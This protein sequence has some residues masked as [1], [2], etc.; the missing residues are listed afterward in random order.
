MKIYI[1]SCSPPRVERLL[2]AA[3]PLHLDFEV[4]DS[5]LGTDEEV[6]RRG[7][8][9]LE[10][11]SGYATGIAATIGHIRA[12][13]RITSRDDPLAIIIEDDVRFHTKFNEYLEMCVSYM[14]VRPCD[15]LSMGYVNMPNLYQ[16]VHVGDLLCIE[17]V[18][19]GNPWGAQCYLITKQYASYFSK[20][21]SGD[22]LATPYDGKFVTD[23]VMF[24]PKLKCN[25][26][27]LYR[28]IVV[29]D[30]SEQTLAGNNNKPDLFK[31][32]RKDDFYF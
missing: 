32:L 28:P 14:K 21:F 6:Q 20:L 4:V 5:P 16:T 24:D 17:N 31:I 18:E 12:M 23:C 3:A 11:G 15:I 27:T 10:R 9:C 7:K 1:V 29:E 8:T 2:K 30:P 13:E 26:S 22:D 25:R 19:L